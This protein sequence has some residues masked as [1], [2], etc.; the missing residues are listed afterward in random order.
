VIGGNLKEGGD[1]HGMDLLSRRASKICGRV[2]SMR[3]WA[4]E[5]LD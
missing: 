3:R 5:G 4:A 2:T 1:E